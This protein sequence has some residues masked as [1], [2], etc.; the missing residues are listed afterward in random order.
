MKV[1]RLIIPLWGEIYAQKLVSIT[2]P[3]L[4]ADGNL[5]AL[6]RMFDV[7]LVLVTESRLFQVIQRAKSFT[8]VAKLCRT[9]LVSLDDLLTDIPGDYGVTLTY[10]LFRGFTDLGA[11]MTERYLIFLNAD[12]I[13]CDGSLR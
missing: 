8:R 9:R 11:E 10:A 4:L 3:A 5:P 6:S 7:E 12:F 1:V 13:I 2:L